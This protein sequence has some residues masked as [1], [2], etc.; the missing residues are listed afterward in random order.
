[1]KNDIIRLFILIIILSFSIQQNCPK[2]EPF[3]KYG[4]CTSSCTEKQ[5]EDKI[6]IISNEIFKIQHLNKIITNIEELLFTITTINNNNEILFS[7]I[8]L[9]SG[10]LLLYSLNSNNQ[11]NLEKIQTS[12]SFL[13]S[14]NFKIFSLL[15]EIKNK[16]DNYLLSCFEDKCNLINYSNKKEELVFTNDKSL[17]SG[18]TNFLFKLNEK[19]NYFYG[20]VNTKYLIKNRLW[21]H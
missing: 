11:L 6:C 19:Y 20:N 12:L 18:D 15:I 4:S 17:K 9:L 2:S 16:L 3:L 13:I 5:I 8:V 10:R 7:S 21:I 1:M 14:E